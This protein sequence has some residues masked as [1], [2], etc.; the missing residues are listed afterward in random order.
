MKKFKNYYIEDAPVNATGTAVPGTG[1]DS[2][3][4]VVKK[5]TKI[6]RKKRKLSQEEIEEAK[7]DSKQVAALKK[8]YEPMRG[9]KISV[10]NGN[11]L[12]KIID[13][14]ENDKEMLIQ[15]YKADIPFVS[16]LAS[17]RLLSKHKMSPAEIK[18][19]REAR[20]YRKEYDNYHSKPEQRE[21]NAARL[22]A[23]RLMIKNGKADR[24]DGKD[25]HHKDNNP[26]NNDETN[27]KLTD[28]SWNRR[29]PRLREMNEEVSIKEFDSM[30][31]GDKVEIEFTSAMSGGKATF[32]VKNKSQSKKYNLEKITLVNV[33]NPNG[34][35]YFLYKR[36]GK[37][38]MAQ[39]DLA[40][41][42]K[43]LK[44][45]ELEEGVGKLKNAKKDTEAM[46]KAAG[47]EVDKQTT[48]KTK[49]GTIR[50]TTYKKIKEADV[51]DDP[52]ADKA[53]DKELKIAK[54]IAQAQLAIAK[55]NERV[56]KLTA[57]QQKIKDSQKEETIMSKKYFETKSGS[58]EE[59]IYSIWEK[60]KDLPRQLKDPKKE[61]MVVKNG[62]VVVIDKKEYKKMEKMG[63]A[64]AESFSPEEVV[65]A[66]QNTS[67][68]EDSNKVDGRS[69]AYREAVRRIKLRHERMKAAAKSK[70]VIEAEE[71]EYQKFFSK[72]LAKFGVKSPAELEGDKEKEFY[73]YVDKN[74]KGEGEKKEQTD[75]K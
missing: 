42:V 61:M 43:S 23:R 73:D 9:K 34:V 72:A 19:I 21:R 22:R 55:E 38:S 20:D 64:P 28:P 36:K 52:Q 47:Y 3:T 33:K 51:K 5:S 1:D 70:T 59:S 45:E 24:G 6:Y 2:S 32:L 27:L 71:T 46:R 53:K 11:K 50:K 37:V 67:S 15:L 30:K 60:S 17:S 39:G 49:H 35:K 7:F 14:I 10:E 4:V 41:A 13:K 29:E 63:W 18:S 54:A 74:W 31:K 8:E 56:Q 62:I 48:K 75:K 16:L 58:L 68:K 25:V 12:R 57:L 65:P 44:M 69:K 40:V 66:K 26:L